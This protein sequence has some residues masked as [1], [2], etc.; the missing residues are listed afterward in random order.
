[1]RNQLPFGDENSIQELVT[2]DLQ[3]SFQIVAAHKRTV[4]G[5]WSYPEHHHP[6]FE[7]NMVLEGEQTLIAENSSF[8]QQAGDILFIPPSVTHRSEGSAGKETMTYFCLHFD[9]DDLTLR[10]SLMGMQTTLL[11]AGDPSSAA[12][13][14][15]LRRLIMT[16]PYAE[17]SLQRDKLAFLSDTFL[18]LSALSRWTIEEGSGELTGKDATENEVS[19]AST[20]ERELRGSS[21]AERMSEERIGVE[22]LAA[23]LGYS[24]TYCK[25]V[26]QRVYGMSP[27]QYLT[28]LIVRQAKLLLID[29]EL[30]VEAIAYQLGYQ[31]VS[32]FS[33][34]FK[35][36]MNMSP[37]AFRRLTK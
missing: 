29:S 36:W 12:I 24:S 2:P 15:A 37:T 19:L 17:T 3:F 28:G 13:H 27:R 33:K 14:D 35:R 22:K 8:V 26:F 34:Q 21:A 7:L 11:S 10:R 32:Q 6:M 25:R 4:N 16:L 20:I 1:M 30:T 31:D 23:R 18:M 9:I 5:Q